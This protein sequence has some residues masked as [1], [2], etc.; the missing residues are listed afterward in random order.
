MIWSNLQIFYS[1]L[2]KM[3]YHLMKSC[4]VKK[5]I[6]LTFYLFSGHFI[7]FGNFFFNAWSMGKIKE[8]FLFFKKSEVQRGFYAFLSFFFNFHIQIILYEIQI[9]KCHAGVSRKKNAL[10]NL[11]FS[12]LSLI[13]SVDL[14]WRKCLISMTWFA[15]MYCITLI[16]R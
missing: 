8:R 5:E 7:P 9:Y 13:F 4:Y 3:Q 16:W 11:T 2:W 15:S 1:C 10:H 14:I 12:S 6:K